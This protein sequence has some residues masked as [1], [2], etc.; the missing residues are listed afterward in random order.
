MGKMILDKRFV[1]VA[2]NPLQSTSENTTIGGIIPL[3][4]S[5]VTY[6]F[7]DV[8]FVHDIAFSFVGRSNAK[9]RE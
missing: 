4:K 2:A 8:S 9:D 6:T 7:L 5:Y 1:I 3:I